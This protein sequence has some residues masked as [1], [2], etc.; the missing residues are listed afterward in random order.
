MSLIM[1]DRSEGAAGRAPVPPKGSAVCR[2]HV[3]FDGSTDLAELAHTY[4][5]EPEAEAFAAMAGRA[6]IPW[7]LGRV[8]AKDAVR[9]HLVSR[10]PRHPGL[11]RTQAHRRRSG[12]RPGAVSGNIER[13]GTAAL[14]HWQQRGTAADGHRHRHRV[15]GAAPAELR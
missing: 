12:R 10:A 2:A 8:A 6:R 3:S 11:H 9:H 4:L 7:L 14:G 15:R 1:H 13:R 5:A